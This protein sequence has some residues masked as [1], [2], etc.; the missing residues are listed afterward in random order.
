MLFPRIPIITQTNRQ[1]HITTVLNSIL[2]HNSVFEQLSSKPNF[3]SLVFHNSQG[4]ATKL[5]HYLSDSFYLNLDI[6]CLAE[7][8][9]PINNSSITDFQH[10]FQIPSL[11]RNKTGLAVS[12]KSSISTNLLF[13]KDSFKILQL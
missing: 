8:H 1:H 13:S 10:C 12:F 7:L 11:N 6:F 9:S 2:Y 4:C 3:L 5:I